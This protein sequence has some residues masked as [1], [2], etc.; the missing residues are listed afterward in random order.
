MKQKSTLLSFTFFLISN[1]AFSQESN[2]IFKEQNIRLPN[3][4]G[5]SKTPFEFSSLAEWKNEY[6]L[7]IPAV[8]KPTKNFNIY[9]DTIY[10]IK[11][12]R[13]IQFINDT[14][15]KKDK[16]D[17]E[18]KDLLKI[19]FNRS[20]I[21]NIL[22][23][24]DSE[25]DGIEGTAIIGNDIYFSIESG[26]EKCYIL[27]GKIDD[28]DTLH[29]VI[30]LENNTITLFKPY[31]STNAGFESFAYLNFGGK[32]QLLAIFENEVSKC[33]NNKC[34][35]YIVDLSKNPIVP[36]PF[37]IYRPDEKGMRFADIC[38]KEEN[39]I[40]GIWSAQWHRARVVKFDNKTKKFTV[41]GKVDKEGEEFN[42]E[43]I[44][45][46]EKGVLMVTD[47]RF[48]STTSSRL[49]YFSLE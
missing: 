28:T 18:D 25:Y 45:G 29:P 47:N 11:K 15:K 30:S 32:P 33:D 34:D 3:S 6:I 10:A 36:Q 8:K 21:D 41:I 7:L 2:V 48:N 17:L 46:F 31:K 35:G 40:Y 14:S 4:I 19:L 38:V 37:K 39:E 44:V 43:G 5:N 9:M 1:I 12:K 24:I 23:K 42:W 26:S 16:K 49:S 13:I 20:Q 27:K 22:F